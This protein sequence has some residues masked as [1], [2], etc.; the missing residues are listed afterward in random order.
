MAVDL[1]ALDEALNERTLALLGDTITY[2][3]GGGAALPAF[4]AIVEHGDAKY[5]LGFSG[6]VASDA[7]AEVPVATIAQPN[8]ADVVSLA[9][10]G[11]DYSPKQYRRDES[12]LNWLILLKVRPA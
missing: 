8:G 3:P 10:T 1:E 4:K 7:A 2:R 9:R 5:E 11:L 12:G 6:A